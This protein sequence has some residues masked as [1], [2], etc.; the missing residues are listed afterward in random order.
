LTNSSCN[1][2]GRHQHS[3]RPWNGN[4]RAFSFLVLLHSVQCLLGSGQAAAVAP[5]PLCVA[6]DDCVTSSCLRICMPSCR[7]ASTIADGSDLSTEQCKHKGQD[8]ALDIATAACKLA[9][10]RGR[11]SS[12]GTIQ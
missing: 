11:G 1:S 9:Q 8:A 7:T 2:T 5:G 6:C 12:M 4:S 10:V 3:V